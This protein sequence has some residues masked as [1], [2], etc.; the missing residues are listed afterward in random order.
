LCL[1]DRDLP[2]VRTGAPQLQRPPPGRMPPHRRDPP[3]V[4]PGAGDRTRMNDLRALFVIPDDIAYFNCAAMTPLLTSVRDAGSARLAERAAPW[5]IRHPEAY[6]EQAD[7]A[8]S[9]F[10][11]LI[12]ADPSG[13]AITP[14]TS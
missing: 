10:S 7:L 11:R 13:I 5:M 9:L 12:N 4:G 2:A 1:R 14:A 8:R 3:A 6:Y